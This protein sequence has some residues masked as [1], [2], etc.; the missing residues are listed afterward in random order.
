M[1]RF[2]FWAFAVLVLSSHLCEAAVINFENAPTG[3]LAPAYYATEGVEITGASIFQVPVGSWASAGS[4][5]QGMFPTAGTSIDGTSW[6]DVLAAHG[7][8]PSNV[9]GAIADVRFFLPETNQ[10]VSIN[11]FSIGYGYDSDGGETFQG[12]VIQA[13]DSSN[14]LVLD[15]N[16]QNLYYDGYETFS[17]PGAV[18]L[19]LTQNGFV[20]FDDLSFN[21]VPEPSSVIL[22]STAG[23]SL[24]LRR[25]FRKIR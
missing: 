1:F 13:F 7:I 15:V 14:N 24:L 25:R 5:I 2:C 18:R 9:G 23:I 6:Q 16:R 8:S 11:S 12:V 22:F 21:A 4:G 19:R 3:P 10:P 20:G 17:A